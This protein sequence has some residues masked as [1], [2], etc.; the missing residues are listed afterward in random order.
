MR[1]LL[2]ALLVQIIALALPAPSEAC[3]GIRLKAQDGS[4][5]FARTMEFGV[6]INSDVVV[7]PRGM[8]L[9]GTMP[10]GKT[11][12][13]WKTKY[14][15]VGANAENRPLIMDGINEKGLSIGYFYFPGFAQYATPGAGD[16]GRTMGPA[17]FGVWALTN[18][19]SVAE[20][21]AALTSIV[22]APTPLP[23]LG[24]MPFHFAVYDAAGGS[25]VIEPVNGTLKIYDNPIGVITNSPTFDWHLTNLRNYI[26]LTADNA[27]PLKLAGVEFPQFGQGSGLLGLPGD[28]TPPSRFVRAVFYSLFALP[29]KN[30]E[31]AVLEAFHILNNFD[32]PKGS[33]R[34]VEGKKMVPET[35]QWTSAKDLANKRYYFHTYDDRSLRMVDLMKFD[36]N[37][38]AMKSVSM[39]GTQPIADVS[40]KAK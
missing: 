25:I 33:V 27:P 17:D 26:N 37:E 2:I 3:T 31:A 22:V 11:G 12:I 5:I 9:A 29:M 1:L 16:A 14:A 36:L 4:V 23:K 6:Q 32:I 7:I 38:K 10:D 13:S 19:A 18:F 40:D 30:A 34:A 24:L 21:K 28:G 8:E 15:V 20:L 35:T 39:K